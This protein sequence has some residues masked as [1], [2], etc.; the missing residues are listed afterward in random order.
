MNTSGC[1]SFVTVRV[2]VI[3]IYFLLMWIA[4]T[5]TVRSTECERDVTREKRL[6]SATGALKLHTGNT[7]IEIDEQRN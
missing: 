1:R 2:S 5:R 3:G 4:R 7:E 6:E